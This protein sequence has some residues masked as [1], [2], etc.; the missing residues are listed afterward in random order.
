MVVCHCREVTDRCIAAAIKAGAHD[1]AAVT[2]RCGAGGACG[3]CVPALRALLA[4]LGV[5]ED[6]ERAGAATHAA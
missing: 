2:R 1:P 4:S 3:G 5:P 6:L